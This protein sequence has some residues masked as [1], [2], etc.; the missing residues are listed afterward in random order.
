MARA[1]LRTFETGQVFVRLESSFAALQVA[2][3]QVA[4]LQVDAAGEQKPAAVGS[5]QY[6]WE[7]T[8]TAVE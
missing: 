5:E 3:L 2:A 6:V 7:G 1:R 8:Q 4:A